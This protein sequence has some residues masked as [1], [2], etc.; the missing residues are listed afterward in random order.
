MRLL[1]LFSI[2]F[3]LSNTANAQKG[4][5]EKQIVNITH[6]L[7]EKY[8]PQSKKNNDVRFD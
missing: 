4:T 5:P 8:F 1:F 2:L 3:I 7:I 6:G